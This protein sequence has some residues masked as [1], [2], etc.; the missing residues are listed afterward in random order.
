MAMASTNNPRKRKQ[1]M[2]AEGSA[3]DP[4]VSMPSV[5]GAAGSSVDTS[6]GDT[7][8]ANI[9][10]KMK[11]PNG[12]GIRPDTRSR[13]DGSSAKR[14][15]TSN[16][17]KVKSHKKVQTGSMSKS[18]DLS[19]QI[20]KIDTGD[21]QDASLGD[22][23]RS[24]SLQAGASANMPVASVSGSIDFSGF[25]EKYGDI[26]EEVGLSEGAIA[27]QEFMQEKAEEREIQKALEAKRKRRNRIIRWVVG[28]IVVL[29]LA[30][31]IAVVAAFSFFR[32]NAYDD[33]ADMQGT[34]KV[35]GTEAQI[36]ISDDLIKLTDDVAYKYVIDPDSKTIQFTFG[37]LV[38]KGHYR[39]SLDRSMLSIMDGDFEWGETLSEDAMWTLDALMDQT[40]NETQKNP[41]G[42]ANITELIKV[43]DSGTQES[44]DAA[45]QQSPESQG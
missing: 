14:Q 34:W 27:A 18:A 5:T 29:I 19:E 25:R 11:E 20:P 9:G 41:S 4:S 24:G 21:V 45:A 2:K 40:F 15:P 39:F 44:S 23:S 17:P 38:G 3:I 22:A 16:R 35:A 42:D 30:A 33:H 13:G 12:S 26:D 28:T 32:W 6:S 37:N 8:S 10:S 36:I 43:E 7:S 31:V 1:Q